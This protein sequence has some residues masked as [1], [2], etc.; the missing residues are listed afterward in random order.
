M[1]NNYFVI[2]WNCGTHEAMA[3]KDED[4]YWIDALNKITKMF[5][6]HL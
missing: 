4:I 3:L 6:N 1:A 2:Y 5:Y